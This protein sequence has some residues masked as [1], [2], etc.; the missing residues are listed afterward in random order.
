VEALREPCYPSIPDVSYGLVR[1]MNKVLQGGHTIYPTTMA[2]FETSRRAIVKP[3]TK[4]D[5]RSEEEMS[6]E[7]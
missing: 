1:Y 7:K 4:N 5:K 3:L 6:A 2:S